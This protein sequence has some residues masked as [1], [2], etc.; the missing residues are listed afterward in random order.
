MSFVDEATAQ[1]DHCLIHH[2]LRAGQGYGV[3]VMSGTYLL[4]NEKRVGHKRH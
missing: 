3:L 4:V 1:V 2:N